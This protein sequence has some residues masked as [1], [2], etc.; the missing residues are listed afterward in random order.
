M[1]PDP[2]IYLACGLFTLI[3]ALLVRRVRNAIVDHE[4]PMMLGVL[5]CCY[6]IFW[7]VVLGWLAFFSVL[8]YIGTI[9]QATARALSAMREDR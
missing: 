8:H 1:T 4:C 9:L 5:M 2:F 6:L 7:P 3:C